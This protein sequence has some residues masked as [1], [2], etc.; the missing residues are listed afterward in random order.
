MST[1]YKFPKC[2]AEEDARVVDCLKQL[3]IHNSRCHRPRFD[4]NQ[5]LK[6]FNEI[7]EAD[8]VT[9]EQF[10]YI[11]DETGLGML[12]PISEL[13]EEYLGITETT[14]PG[15]MITEDEAKAFIKGG[16]LNA[17]RY[18]RSILRNAET[19][20]FE[21]PRRNHPLEVLLG[22]GQFQEQYNTLVRAV[23]KYLGIHPSRRENYGI[24]IIAPD[25]P[26]ALV[27]L[28]DYNGRSM[29]WDYHVVEPDDFITYNRD[30]NAYIPDLYSILQYILQRKENPEATL[31]PPKSY[32]LEKEEYDEYVKELREQSEALPETHTYAFDISEETYRFAKRKLAEFSK[33]RNPNQDDEDME[34][35]FN[36]YSDIVKTY[37][38][39]H[40]V[41]DNYLIYWNIE[42]DPDEK[43]F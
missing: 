13:P 39:A 16:K 32:T 25:G 8:K 1:P 33:M 9:F 31:V 17:K 43:D 28:N 10:Q 5:M 40:Q 42:R 18:L 20:V 14:Q 24:S 41:D 23:S 7:A 22:E 29:T 19:E 38:D 37:E 11:E 3:S 27:D 4:V 26:A 6:T 15:G 36:I 21:D 2:R 12:Q 35:Q 34:L 30:Y